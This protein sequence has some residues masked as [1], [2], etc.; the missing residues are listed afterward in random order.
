[1]RQ[2]LIKRRLINE[3]PTR[4][5][6]P[7]DFSES[8]DTPVNVVTRPEINDDVEGFVCEM[9]LAHILLV[10][11]RLKVLAEDPQLSIPRAES[12]LG[13]CTEFTDD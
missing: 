4:T 10:D 12:A 13:T 3:N 5:E 7:A 11:L 8:H 1:M 2:E 9:E 6:H